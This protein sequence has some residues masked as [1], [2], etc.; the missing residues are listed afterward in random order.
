MKCVCETSL[1]CRGQVTETLYGIRQRNGTQPELVQL[2]VHMSFPLAPP[3]PF[4][5]FVSLS[6]PICV[7][8]SLCVSLSLS[9]SLA[10]SVRPSLSLYLPPSSRVAV[11]VDC[12]PTVVIETVMQTARTGCLSAWICQVCACAHV[13]EKTPEC[14]RLREEVFAELCNVPLILR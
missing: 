4:S 6:L 1:S 12:S 3:P 10:L 7:C 8:L 14:S 9:L 11:F 13:S 5:P 2:H